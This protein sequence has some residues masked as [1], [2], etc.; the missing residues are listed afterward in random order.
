M[1]LSEKEELEAIKALLAKYD[2][3]FNGSKDWSQ[4]D[5]LGKVDWLASC[6]KSKW[7]EVDLLWEMLP[8]NETKKYWEQF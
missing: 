4:S 7:Q 1:Q 3:D 8:G 6:L 2:C 5:A